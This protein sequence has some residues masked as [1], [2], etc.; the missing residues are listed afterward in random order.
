MAS[1][2]VRRETMLDEGTAPTACV[3]RYMDA[4]NAKDLDG[5]VAMFRRDGVVIFPG[6]ETAH[7]PEEIGRF[8]ASHFA[9]FDYARVLHVEDVEVRE[10][11]AMVRSHTTGTI[12]PLTTMSP[13]EA[14]SRELFVLRHGGDVW[15]IRHYMAN[16]PAPLPG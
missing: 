8:Y 9:R 2:T 1:T 11:L 7:G 16:Q 14:V 6:A 5:L 15:R 13:V 4:L 12:T 10:D 3:A